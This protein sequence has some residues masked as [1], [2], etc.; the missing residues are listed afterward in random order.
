MEVKYQYVK[1]KH[2][3][4]NCWN[5]ARF[6]G[7][8]STL[9]KI[10][11]LIR[12]AVDK[13]EEKILWWDT[14]IECLPDDYSDYTDDN[15]FGSKWFEPTLEREKKDRL[16]IYGNSSWSPPL[17]FYQKICDAYKVSVVADYEESGMNFGGWFECVG[18]DIIR[19]EEVSW[20]RFI[21]TMDPG[22]AFESVWYD[23][24]D[25][26]WES[27]DDFVKAFTDA[28]EIDL[29]TQAEL[30]EAREMIEKTEYKPNQFSI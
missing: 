14:Y 3:A 28:G 6:I 27:Y 21:N 2:M 23:I 16:V 1:H 25:G 26:R 19:D 12:D 5:H 13:S 7:D 15:S 10:E 9:D 29:F 24:E 18:G 30:Q 17:G 4:N 22:R 20:L 11:S 8:K